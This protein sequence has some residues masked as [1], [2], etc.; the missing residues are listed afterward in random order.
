MKKNLTCF[1]L[2]T[3]L[4]FSFS[5]CKKKN[6]TIKSPDPEV[7][8]CADVLFNAQTIIDDMKLPPDAALHGTEQLSWGTGEASPYPMP[9]PA[10]NWKG[11]WF[12]ALTNWGQLYIP[13]SG[14]TATNT[15]C[16]IKNV[17]TFILKKDATWYKVQT[18]NPQGAA[19]VEDFANNASMD[20]GARDE[21]AN[22]GGVSVKAGVSNWAGHN[23]HFWSTGSRASIDVNEIVGVFTFCQARL[24]VDDTAKPDDR[25]T[26]KN[27]LQMGADWWLGI[28]G[29]WL[30]D[31]SA[32]SGIGG[33]RSKWVTSDWQY[34][35]MCTIPPDDLKRNPPCVK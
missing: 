4:L 15:R 12:Q 30:P 10:K 33:G 17:T 31:W 6:D 20:A 34:F 16:Q 19:Y 9:V 23:Y 1:A 24:I 7:P 32:N 28:N 29:G 27:I 8:I 26:C 11:E 22:G 25:A 21:T 2:S 35:T 14:S 18:G 3:V 13:R 5:S